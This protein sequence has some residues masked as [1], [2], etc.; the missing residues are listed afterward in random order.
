[1]SFEKSKYFVNMK[2]IEKYIMW[3]HESEL[4]FHKRFFICL[5]VFNAIFD[6]IWWWALLVEK[7]GETSD[8]SQVTVKL[9]HIML[10]TSPWSRFELTTSVVIGTDCVGSCKSSYHTITTTTDTVTSNSQHH[11]RSICYLDVNWLIPKISA[12][13]ARIWSLLASERVTI[14]IFCRT[15]WYFSVS[16]I[17]TFIQMTCLSSL[18][19]T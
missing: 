1:M 13:R 17:F 4:S 9:Y 2:D 7:T 6:N 8:L 12:C 15:G 11:K 14:F 5:M 18:N 19:Q 16:I 3:H 10:Y